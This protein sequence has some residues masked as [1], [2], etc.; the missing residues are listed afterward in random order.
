MLITGA[1]SALPY[2]CPYLP[3]PREPPRAWSQLTAG[4]PH[5]LTLPLELGQDGSKME[6]EVLKG[7][8]PGEGREWAGRCGA[9][10]ETPARGQSSD[11]LL[12]PH[13]VCR[14]ALSARSLGTPGDPQ[15]APTQGPQRTPS[16][17]S[18]APPGP[19]HLRCALNHTCPSLLGRASVPTLHFISEEPSAPVSVAHLAPGHCFLRSPALAGPPLAA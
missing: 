14:H 8:L 12:L 1:P 18:P 4:S 15:P 6:M 16:L 17:P 11:S 13:Q 7:P 5:P 3:R 10:P 19:L 9:H 2:W